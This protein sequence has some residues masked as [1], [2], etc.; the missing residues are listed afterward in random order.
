MS[1]YKLYT[2]PDHNL[3]DKYADAR[4]AYDLD[5]ELDRAA[6]WDEM[7]SDDGDIAEVLELLTEYPE[8]V[9]PLLRAYRS[10]DCI[11]EAAQRLAVRLDVLTES[12]IEEGL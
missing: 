7:L 10:G 1:T 6:A 2:V 8:D 5:L 11:R 12:V 4:D 3:T 9:L